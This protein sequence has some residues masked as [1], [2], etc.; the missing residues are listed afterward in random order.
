VVEL[1]AAGATASAIAQELFLTPPM[2]ER[3]LGALRLRFGVADDRA[4]AAALPAP[5]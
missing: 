1:A 5:A 3:A 4:L 2:V